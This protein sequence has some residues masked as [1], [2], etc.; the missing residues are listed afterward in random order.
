LQRSKS[1]IIV[2]GTNYYIESILWHNLVAPAVGFK[3]KKIDDDDD[4]GDSNS[5]DEWSQEVRDFVSDSAM[6]ENMLDMESTKLY[7]YLKLIDPT[8]A[9][10]LH[11]N[12]KRKIMR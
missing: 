1:P 10:R 3:R 9:R 8:T 6:V 7:E 12:N 2:G 5:E 11:P 4:D